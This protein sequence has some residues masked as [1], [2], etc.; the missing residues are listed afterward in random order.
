MFTLLHGD[1]LKASR[2]EFNLLRE[3]SQNYD[4][5]Y[6]EGSKLNSTKLLEAL[7]TSSMLLLPKLIIIENLFNKKKKN[8]Y[9]EILHQNEDKNVLIWEKSEIGKTLLATLPKSTQVK[10]FKLPFLIFKFLETL[11]PENSKDALYLFQECLKKEEPEMLFYLLVRQ[12][13]NLLITKKMPTGSVIELSSWQ[14][15]K[16]TSQ[17]KY[18]TMEQLLHMYQELLKIDISVKTGLSPFN[19]TKLFEQYLVFNL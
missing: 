16:L 8:E 7:E 9:Q 11:R 4:I 2:E 18:F 12:I 15:N 6:L 10:L 17:G 1:N 19:L 14:I 3:K 5:I 13:R